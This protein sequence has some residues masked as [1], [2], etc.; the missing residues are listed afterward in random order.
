[1]K[2]T[3]KKLGALVLV[4]VMMLS[5]SV[6]AFATDGDL[7][8]DGIVGNFTTADETNFNGNAVILY[9]EITAYNKDGKA[10]NAPT[11]DY[12]Y[13]ITGLVG[14]MSVKDAGGAALHTTE[15][16]VEV[17]TKDASSIT[18]TI[19]G[20]VDDGTTYV[21]GKLSLTP[22]VSLNTSENGTAN[23][24]K[25]KVTFTESA[26]TSAGVYRFKI[27]ETTTETSKN[28]AGIKEGTGANIL[29]LDVYVK[30]KDAS[31]AGQ[32]IYGYVLFTSNVAI[33][34]TSDLTSVGKVEGFVDTNTS[35]TVTT[36]DE[37]F[38]FNV[39]VSKT[40]VGDTYSND[41]DFPF[42]VN[43]K[44]SSVSSAIVIKTESSEN[45]AA[46]TN[47][48]LASGT[49]STADT[50]IEATP[51]IDHQSY[52][53]YVGVPV[54]ITAATTVDVYENNDVTGT[55]YKSSNKVDNVTAST[56][57]SL[58]WVSPG[59]KSDVANLS[60]LVANQKDTVSHT[61]AFTNTL[62]IISP[63]GVALRV[64]P[65]VLM[66]SV[67]MILVLFSRRRKAEEEA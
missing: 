23:K 55:I 29:Y 67:G 58:N 54:G 63:T 65:Y 25:L 38:T 61:I 39:K 12:A 46:A 37:Y 42:H 15:N 32:Y 3:F 5:L 34:G 56:A 45:G 44:N 28:A 11:I 14:G 27:E 41:H 9:K 52:V 43:F 26:F 16:A 50:G 47:G 1:M 64:A 6:A 49:L 7:G 22:S 30:D 57:K 60:T 48:A 24:F 35:E 2:N 59:N 17:Q 10:V 51:G 21:T 53:T 18:A 36:A 8:G 66:L 19:A 40:L 33:D 4:V 31:T 62:E 20:S 13:T